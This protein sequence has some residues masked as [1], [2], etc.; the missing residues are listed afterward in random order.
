MIL[1]EKTMN[2]EIK[3]IEITEEELESV[4]GGNHSDFGQILPTSDK[5]GIDFLFSNPIIQE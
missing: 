5:Q 3:K 1:K 4:S 2:E